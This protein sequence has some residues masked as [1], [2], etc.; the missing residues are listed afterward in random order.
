MGHLGRGGATGRPRLPST[1]MDMA[2]AKALRRGK[3][4][5][6]ERVQLRQLEEV[7]E[8]ARRWQQEE[9]KAL[10]AI[11]ERKLWRGSHATFED[12]G[13][14]RWGIEHSQ[15]Y[16]L[17]SWGEVLRTLSP[18][19]EKVPARETHARALYGLLAEQQIEAWQD[20]LNR[21]PHRIT[22]GDVELAVSDMLT[23]K[24]PVRKPAAGGLGTGSGEVV[25]GDCLETLQSL[26][27]GTVDLCLTSP[28][29]AEQRRGYYPS[30]PEKEFVGWMMRVMAS[31]KPKLSS[32]GSVLIV[33]REHV[34]KGQ[35]SDY[36][37]RTRLALRDAGWIE[38]E[39]LIWHS[40]DK[41]PLGSKNRPR[42]TY[43]HIFWFARTNAPYVDLRACGAPIKHERSRMLRPRMRKTSVFEQSWRDMFQ[44][45]NGSQIA[46]VS[47][48]ITAPVGGVSDQV[49]HAAMFPQSLANQ[50]I[51]TYSP[52][53]GLVIDPMCGSGTTLL[54][55]REAGRHWWG[56]DIVPRHV[57]LARQ[58]LAVGQ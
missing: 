47:D 29:Y 1:T 55:A 23:R 15:L 16:R 25:C 4:A 41:P 8:T 14:D 18:F 26:S 50:L 49:N 38:C 46:R 19:G 57:E 11:R 52:N 13:R 42:R 33:A 6:L 21:T 3:L 58:R 37:L 56:C 17:T 51:R 2:A 54:A 5:R 40:P 48:L 12:Y 43:E 9:A 24:H 32:R 28:P 31:L 30:V 20:V 36:W 10:L 7:L 34:R 39:T 22:A 45:F 35:I 27:Q 44:R 53:N